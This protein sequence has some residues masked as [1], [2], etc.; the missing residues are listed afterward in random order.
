VKILSGKERGNSA[1]AAAAPLVAM[2]QLGPDNYEVS[3]SGPTIRTVQAGQALATAV[4]TSV[5]KT[6]VPVLGTHLFEST[7]KLGADAPESNSPNLELTQRF[8]CT[9]RSA[10]AQVQAPATYSKEEKDQAAAKVLDETERYFR[11]LGT[12]K[13]DEAFTQLDRDSGTFSEAAWKRLKR[14]FLTLAGALQRIAITKVTVYENPASASKPGLY[15]AADYRITWANVR[16]Q[17][18]YLVWLRMRDGEFRILR[19]ETGHV[20]AEQLQAMP[21]AQ[22]QTVEQALRCR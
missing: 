5:C 15:V 4:A 16:L 17:C 21:Q 11:L 2:R 6:L 13:V 3:L 12:G 8:T 7:E 19:E 10:P 22:R 14:D 18:G 1:G 20:T 9:A